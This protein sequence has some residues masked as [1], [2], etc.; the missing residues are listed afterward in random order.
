MSI[1]RTFWK[2]ASICEVKELKLDELEGFA[3]K[4]KEDKLS[5]LMKSASSRLNEIASARERVYAAVQALASSEPTEEVY[6]KLYKMGDEAR[7]RLFNKAMR[8]LSSI[9]VPKHPTWQTLL[10]FRD[11]ILRAAGSMMEASAVH[12]RYAAIIFEKQT[13][14]F[15]RSIKRFGELAASFDAFLRGWE[16]ELQKLESICSLSRRRRELLESL[17]GL[18]DRKGSLEDEVRSLGQA[19]EEE[20]SNLERFLA[21]DLVELQHLRQEVEEL[22]RKVKEVENEIASTLSGLS[23]PLRKMKN[24]LALEGH[25]LGRDAIKTLERY[26]ND[27]L[28]TILSEDDGLPLLNLLLRDLLGLIQNGKLGLDAKEREKRLRQIQGLLNS[29]VLLKF[30][31]QYRGLLK[32]ISAKKLEFERSPLHARRAE[33][34]KTVQ[35]GKAKLELARE[36]LE[37]MAAKIEELELQLQ[38]NAAELERISSDVL[39][40]PVKLI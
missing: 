25:R 6:P 8:A 15:I 30:Q 7:R 34:E 21:H 9:E 13:Q 23:R 16:L 33:L 29:G 17:A 40:A 35:E 10:D 20:T 3:K 31:T 38:E 18:R 11:S 26:L 12:G 14:N 19:L 27:P 24:V 22:E 39:G 4:L 5:D 37:A 2:R 36:R 1:R 28:R 32:E